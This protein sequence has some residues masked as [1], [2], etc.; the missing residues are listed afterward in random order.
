[1][2][3]PNRKRP[4]QRPRRKFK[5]RCRPSKA[6]PAHPPPVNVDPW[7]HVTLSFEDVQTGGLACFTVKAIYDALDSQL[8]LN[9][10]GKYYVLRVHRIRIWNMSGGP[11]FFEPCQLVEK[12]TCSTEVLPYTSIEEYAGRNTWA[13]IQYSW[14]RNLSPMLDSNYNP[15]QADN[16]GVVFLRKGRKGELFVIHLSVSF[17]IATPNSFKSRKLVVIN[18]SV[19]G[20]GGTTSAD[21]ELDD[22]ENLEMQPTN[23][24]RVLRSST[25]AAKTPCV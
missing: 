20:R 10:S 19:S 9:R 21:T 5:R 6:G 11:I 7:F 23:C 2:V 3:R 17:K 4:R 25:R 16:T 14:P 24:R 1:M 22:F 8:S 13:R 15:D 12:H 18:P